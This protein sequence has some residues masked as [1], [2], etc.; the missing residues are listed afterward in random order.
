MQNG[1]GG[2][3]RYGLQKESAV[4]FGGAAVQH[5]RGSGGGAGQ[6]QR[7]G[8]AG[9][10]LRLRRDETGLSGLQGTGTAVEDAGEAAF[11][12]AG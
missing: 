11:G 10:S 9:C 8:G 7:A 6:A 4:G 3:K 12:A 1:M 2:V 5:G